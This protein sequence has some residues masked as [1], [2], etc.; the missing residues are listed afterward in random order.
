M[1]KNFYYI[2]LIMGSLGITYF[3]EMRKE[4]SKVKE[5]TP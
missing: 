2:I 3:I 5:E 1:Y 4:K